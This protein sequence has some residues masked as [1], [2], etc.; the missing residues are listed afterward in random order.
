MTATHNGNCQCC[1]SLQ[2]VNNKTGLLAKHGYTV[3]WGFFSGTCVGSDHPPLQKDHTVLDGTVEALRVFA[4]KKASMT[5]DK[6]DEVPVIRRENA[7]RVTYMMKADEFVSQ[8]AFKVAAERH[9]QNL[10]REGQRAAERAVFLLELAD[11]IHGAE[12]LERAVEKPLQRKTVRDYSTAFA[13]VELLKG[14]GKKNVRQRKAGAFRGG[15]TV[16]WRD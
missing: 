16:T 3:D 13:L 15:F 4:A 10:H 2:A 14:K 5:I 1:G 12:L 9:L 11:R 7:I 8:R 6:I